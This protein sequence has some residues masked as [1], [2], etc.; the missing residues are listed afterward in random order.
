LRRCRVGDNA[1]VTIVGKSWGCGKN[2][3]R[4]E[5]LDENDCDMGDLRACNV[6]AA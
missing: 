5:K 3:L 6:K 1:L 2:Q 4:D